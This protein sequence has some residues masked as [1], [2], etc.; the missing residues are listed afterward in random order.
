MFP[1]ENIGMFVQ[2]GKLTSNTGDTL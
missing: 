2:G 1:L